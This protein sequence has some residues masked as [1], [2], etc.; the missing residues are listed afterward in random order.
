MTLIRIFHVVIGAA[1]IAALAVA[2]A[3][4]SGCGRMQEG[5]RVENGRTD[6]LVDATT[7]TGLQFT[8]VNG[9]TGQFYYPEIIAPGVALLD[10]D[11]DGDLD[12]FLVQGGPLDGTKAAGAAAPG[13]RLYRNDL[14]M[15]PEGTRVFRF[16]AVTE[17]SGIRPAGYGMG[18][19]AGDYDNDGCVD[20]YLTMLGRNQL[21]RNQCD[22]TFREVAAQ[23][24]VDDPGWSVSAAFLD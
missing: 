4:V 11:G 23:A 6:W 21:F 24:G 13:G 20:L 17:A 1:V 10:Y 3:S 5:D 15:R 22:G 18:A 2:C 14:E 19:A 16:T 12:V 8:H 7:E 9:M